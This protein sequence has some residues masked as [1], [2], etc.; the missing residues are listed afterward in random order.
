MALKRGE[1]DCDVNDAYLLFS[2][3]KQ[4][5]WKKVLIDI[6]GKI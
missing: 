4:K 6:F 3:R 2:E 1:L 5:I